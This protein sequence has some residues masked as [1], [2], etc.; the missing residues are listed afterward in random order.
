MKIEKML[1][2]LPLPLLGLAFGASLA[3]AFAT[4]AES[5]YIYPQL[6]KVP[7]SSLNFSLRFMINLSSQPI[8]F[9]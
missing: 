1:R 6:T 7:L 4:L 9:G 5:S 3:I 2:T 8:L